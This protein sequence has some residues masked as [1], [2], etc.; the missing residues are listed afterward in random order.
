MAVTT[1]KRKRQKPF[2]QQMRDDIERL[3]KR[4][5]AGD[6]ELPVDDTPGGAAPVGGEIPGLNRLLR[7]PANPMDNPGRLD[8]QAAEKNDSDPPLS[9]E[10]T[11]RLTEEIGFLR[12]LPE[13]DNDPSDADHDID[14]AEASSFP[15][16]DQ[17]FDQ[18]LAGVE[19][20]S[21]ELAEPEEVDPRTR[22]RELVAMANTGDDAA[23]AEL[24]IM[25]DEHAEIWLTLGNLGAFAEEALITLT[26]EGNVLVAESLRRH[27]QQ[28]RCNL[29]TDPSNQLER[30]TVQRVVASWLHVQHADR[31]AALA[32]AGSTPNL[33]WARRQATAETRYQT[34]LRSLKIVKEISKI[35]PQKEAEDESP[36][37]TEAE[38]TEEQPAQEGK[39]ED[40]E[41]QTVT[42]KNGRC[43]ATSNINGR[44][45]RTRRKVIPQANGLPVNRIGAAF[46]PSEAVPAGA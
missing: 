14:V 10:E 32:D 43:N 33:V 5:N 11:A 1:E 28:M 34:S 39:Q 13:S 36:K 42:P 2:E 15:V 44:A 45:R 4:L 3:V 29:L 27:A 37:R 24:R 30:L 6:I 7:L 8:A 31:M 12:R 26:A 16:F 35:A 18:P 25:L 40:C 17:D 9:A 21:S 19:P 46:T 23:L 20:T 22:L 38:T 41:I